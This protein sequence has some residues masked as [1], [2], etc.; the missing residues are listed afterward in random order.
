MPDERGKRSAAT[1]GVNTHWLPDAI[2][3]AADVVF[4]VDP[5][6]RVRYVNQRVRE[7]TGF[8]PD[9]LVGE[10]VLKLVESGSHGTLLDALRT[11]LRSEGP[12]TQL[13]ELAFN[14]AGTLEPV[15]VEAALHPLCENGRA[16]GC[17]G[18]AR[19]VDKRREY[20]AERLASERVAAIGDLAKSAA[21]KI[22]NPLAILVTHLAVMER[23]VAEDKPC[24]LDSIENMKKVVERIAE[25]TKEL[26]AAADTSMQK[27]V[28]GSAT[29]ELSSLLPP[30][31]DESGSSTR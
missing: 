27:A 2:D 26:A 3:Q 31:D 9:T 12:R 24:D 10:S 22:N 16:V 25:A 1:E 11:A 4:I 30:K 14:R 28:L 13:I 17:I 7:L 8:A 20:H 29:P 5:H 21:H 23:A 15:Y 6:D 18:I 19:D